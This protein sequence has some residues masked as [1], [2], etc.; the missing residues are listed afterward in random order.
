MFGILQCP[1]HPKY[2]GQTAIKRI[3]TCAGCK[4]VRMSFLERLQR[5]RNQG[6]GPYPSLTTPYFNCGLV[7]IFTEVATLMCYG[8]QPPFFWRKGSSAAA[9]IKD[10]YKKTYSFISGWL[11][12]NP[13]A[14]TG[15]SR[16]IFQ[17]CMVMRSSAILNQMTF[18]SEIQKKQKEEFNWMEKESK[19]PLT[20]S[21][22]SAKVLNPFLDE[23]IDAEKEKAEGNSDSKG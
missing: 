5:K 9:H 15:L 19:Q 7:H 10:F 4:A 6:K 23:D 21:I 8:Y 3:E 17:T 13:N 12:K 2:K 11:E 1:D 18:E 16:F 14:K 22:D 20:P